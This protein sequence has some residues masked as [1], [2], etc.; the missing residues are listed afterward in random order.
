MARILESCLPNQRSLFDRAAS[1]LNEQMPIIH[2]IFHSHSFSSF[3]I[4]VSSR[5]FF[6]DYSPSEQIKFDLVSQ[7]LVYDNHSLCNLF[8]CFNSLVCSRIDLFILITGYNAC[9]SIVPSYSKTF[10]EKLHV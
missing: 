9:I 1:D 5:L 7:K 2:T 6:T 4:S 8:R 3:N 10:T